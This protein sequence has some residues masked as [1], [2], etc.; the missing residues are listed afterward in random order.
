M[1]VVSGPYKGSH[2]WTLAKT[3]PLG[4]FPNPAQPCRHPVVGV[5]EHSLQSTRQEKSGLRGQVTTLGADAI[6]LWAHF[7]DEDGEPAQLAQGQPASKEGRW[8]FPSWHSGLR[9]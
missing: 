1:S 7:T 4:P 3:V 2:H 5:A 8:E 9:I 6:S